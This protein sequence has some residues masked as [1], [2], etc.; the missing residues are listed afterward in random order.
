MPVLEPDAAADRRREKARTQTRARR[1][2]QGS[3]HW[4]VERRLSVIICRNCGA[5]I[6]RQVKPSFCPECGAGSA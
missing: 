5:H 4:H 1:N 6:P 3:D 2:H